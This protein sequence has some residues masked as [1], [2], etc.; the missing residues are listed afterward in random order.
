M[1]DERFRGV[2][3]VLET[4]DETVWA[5]EIQMLRRFSVPQ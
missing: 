1:Q 2:P 4:I 5:E 3:L